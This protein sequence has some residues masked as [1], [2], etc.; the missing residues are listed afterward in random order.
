M[1]SDHVPG[2]SVNI[3]SRYSWLYDVVQ[4]VQNLPCKLTGPADLG[5]IIETKDVEKL[6]LL[7]LSIS[8]CDH[9]T[10]VLGMSVGSVSPVRA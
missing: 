7:T 2:M 4:G 3:L 9:S 1:K 8:S 10:G 6:V 5:K